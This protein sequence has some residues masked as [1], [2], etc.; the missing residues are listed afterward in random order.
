MGTDTTSK[1]RRFDP[2]RLGDLV[3]HPEDG[4][5]SRY[6][7]DGAKGVKGDFY[8]RVRKSGTPIYWLRVAVKGK[9]RKVVSLGI[10]YTE[11]LDKAKALTEAGERGILPAVALN[12]EKVLALADPLPADPSMGTFAQ[13]RTM[14]L[15][16]KKAQG[17]LSKRYL[18]DEE[19]LL[20]DEVF[21]SWVK[22][23]IR[24]IQWSKVT[25]A[26]NAVRA[27]AANKVSGKADG[28]GAQDRTWG[29]LKRLWTFCASQGDDDTGRMTNIFLGREKPK[30]DNTGTARALSDDEL[31]HLLPVLRS[32]R[33]PY[34]A[35]L[36]V[37][38][39]TARRHHEVT[40]C[41]WAEIDLHART[42]KLPAERAKN[43]VEHLLPLSDFVVQVLKNVLAEQTKDSAGPDK[44]VFARYRNQP[45]SSLQDYKDEALSQLKGKV[46]HFRIHDLRH[47]A[48]TIMGGIEGVSKETRM[49]VLNQTEGGIN[50]RYRHRKNQHNMRSAVKA[51]GE[52]LS[53]L[54]A[55]RKTETAQAAE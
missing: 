19:L 42:W 25:V 8:V 32:L 33:S 16:A 11:A 22:L 53:T 23:P 12:P 28:K 48:N 29:A 31:R 52:Y 6:K 46:E 15:A 5:E 50:E 51:L 24:S 1:A 2:D 55:P 21:T 38:L 35:A 20:N 43:G 37:A 18:Y 17:D 47:T 39:G 13:A 40:H 49:D 27:R 14:Y 9:G 54:E 10:S 4:D 41:P 3:Y 36:L 7:I 26:L 30:Y 34:G 44:Y 45:I